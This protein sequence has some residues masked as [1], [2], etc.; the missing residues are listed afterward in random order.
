MADIVSPQKRSEMMS[1]IR[2]KNTKPEHFIRKTLHAKGF[3]FRLHRKD[4]PGKPDLV[5]SKY[6]TVIFVHGCFWHGH[7][8]HLFKWPKSRPDFWRAKI[9]KNQEND[10]KAL[11]ALKKD[12]WR[13]LVIWE[14]AIKGKERIEPESI[15]KTMVNWLKSDG[16]FLEIRGAAV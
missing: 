3:R 9:S 4:L 10:E 14:C 1:G 5:L 8:C 13:I 15:M 6:R 12:N 7:D 11:V 2:G 16:E